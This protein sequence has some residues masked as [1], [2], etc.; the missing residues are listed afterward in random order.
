[1][2]AKMT[3][4]N[5]V[6]HAVDVRL[7]RPEGLATL[8]ALAFDLKEKRLSLTNGVGQ[9]DPAAVFKAIG[10]KTAR[11]LEP[12]Q[13]IDPPKVKVDGWIQTCLNPAI[14]LYFWG[15]NKLIRL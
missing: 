12:Y 13:F 8:D 1:M 2:T 7:A 14:N 15:I 6:L 3:L 9:V 4:T 5:G 11:A 10:P